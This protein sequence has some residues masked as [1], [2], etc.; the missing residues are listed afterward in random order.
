MIVYQTFASDLLEA[1]EAKRIYDAF[2]IVERNMDASYFET[3]ATDAGFT[4]IERDVIGGEWREWWEA[5]GSRKTSANLVRA[6]RLIRAEESIRAELGDAAYEF[7]MADQL[8]GIYQMIG[9]LV[10]TMYVL[11]RA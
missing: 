10:P 3:C 7:A 1:Q 9:K 5:E 11:R 2:T 6:A 8:W 4:I